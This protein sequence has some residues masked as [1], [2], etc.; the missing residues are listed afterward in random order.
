MAQ[1]YLTVTGKAVEGGRYRRRFGWGTGAA[2]GVLSVG[3]DGADGEDLVVLFR[4]GFDVDGNN[5]TL[6]GDAPSTCAQ[7]VEYRR[8]Q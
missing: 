1:Q 6:G 8:F 7:G 3:P 5:S 4:V 2:E